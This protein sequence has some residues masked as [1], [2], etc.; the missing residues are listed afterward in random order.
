[1]DIINIK[2]LKENQMNLNH[3]LLLAALNEKTYY[4]G[5]KMNIINKTLLAAAIVASSITVANAGVCNN[6]SLRYGYTLEA[7][8]DGYYGHSVGRIVF[9]T[10]GNVTFSGLVTNPGVQLVTGA[11]TYTVNSN[12][13]AYGTITLNTGDDI[14]FSAFLDQMDDAPA[15]R[16]AYHGSFI[17]ANEQSATLSTGSITKLVGKFQ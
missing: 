9:D 11:G 5:I 6:G 2:Y 16:V 3:K 17:S 8:G 4:Q 13:T 14:T 1:M 15:V 7:N 12:C 10:T